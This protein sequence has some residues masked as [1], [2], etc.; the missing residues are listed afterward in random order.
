MYCEARPLNS[1]LHADHN[2]PLPFAKVI[3]QTV[4]TYGIR[5][6]TRFI[7]YVLPYLRPYDTS[8]TLCEVTILDF[9]E[10]VSLII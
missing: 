6:A 3:H 10:D 7:Q 2:G 5:D 1:R 8:S 9:S 4:T